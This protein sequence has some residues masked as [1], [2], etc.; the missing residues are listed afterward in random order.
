MTET[1]IY[2][3]EEEFATRYHLGRR[4]LQRWRCTGE[5][6]RWCRLGPRRVMYRL[7]DIEDWAK[8]RTYAHRADELARQPA[9]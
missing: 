1:A 7:A 6:P 8:A 3:T 9:A 5:G 4:T 2:L